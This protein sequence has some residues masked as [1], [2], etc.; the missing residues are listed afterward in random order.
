MMKIAFKFF[1][2]QCLCCVALDLD[3][4]L[5]LCKISVRNCVQCAPTHILE[6]ER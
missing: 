2:S 3:S 4:M 1:D 5:E 6:I